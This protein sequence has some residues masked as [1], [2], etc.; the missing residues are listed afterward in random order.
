MNA[1]NSRLH[2]TAELARLDLDALDP[3]EVVALGDQLDRIL[4]YVEHLAA[5][6]TDGVEPT[7]HPVPIPNRRRPDVAHATPGA[8]VIVANAP[9]RRDNEFVI[10]RFVSAGSAGGSDDNE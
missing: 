10:P 2:H 3:A 5:V 4:G 1:S 6:N 7:V 8:A 9:A